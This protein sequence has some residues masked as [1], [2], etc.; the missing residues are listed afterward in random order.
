MLNVDNDVIDR[1]SEY[2]AMYG[3]EKII[4]YGSR[5]NGLCRPDSDYDIAVVGGNY[6]DFYL[7]L[8]YDE[9]FSV[10]FDIHEYSKASGEFKREIDKGIIIYQSPTMGL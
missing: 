1:I 6:T 10:F 5:A 3:V 7:S 2:A 8:Y 9:D 4:L